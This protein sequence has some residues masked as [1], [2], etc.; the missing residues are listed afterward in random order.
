MMALLVNDI[1]I[2]ICGMNIPTFICGDFNYGP[3]NVKNILT[4]NLVFN[5]V[6]G[7]THINP[8]D[9]QKFCIDHVVHNQLMEV[10]NI[11]ISGIDQQAQSMKGLVGTDDNGGVKHDHGMLSF[12]C[13]I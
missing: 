1:F 2:L 10:S 3:L 12:A 6:N 4:Q 13:H 5:P 7:I 8:N 9:G 11:I